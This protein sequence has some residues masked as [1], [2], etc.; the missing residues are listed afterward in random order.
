M[1]RA[2]L[3]LGDMLTFSEVLKFHPITGFLILLFLRN[4]G[5]LI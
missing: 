2:Y 5:W 3:C 1:I 4:V